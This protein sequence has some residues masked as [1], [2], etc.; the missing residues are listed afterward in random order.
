MVVRRAE[1][2]LVTPSGEQR[3][4]QRGRDMSRHTAPAVSSQEEG[5]VT[6]AHGLLCEEKRT[7]FDPFLAIRGSLFQDLEN[8]F[9]E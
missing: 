6:L 3:E 8:R 1:A 7:K 5:L 9:Y 4:G 2:A